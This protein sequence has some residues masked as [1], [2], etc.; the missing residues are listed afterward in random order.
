MKSTWLVVLIGL[1][2]AAGY[3][4]NGLTGKEATPDR[5][6]RE[7][8]AP[9]AAP[10][11]EP[12]TA[13]DSDSPP[14]FADLLSQPDVFS[15]LHMAFE[16]AADSG[17]EKLAALATEALRYEDPLFSFNIAD[18][19]VERMTAIDVDAS[20]DF[21]ESLPAGRSRYQLLTSIYRTWLRQDPEAAHAYADSVGDPRLQARLLAAEAPQGPST[22]LGMR[23]SSVVS[24]GRSGGI[25]YSS[26][27]VANA[28][29]QR[30]LRQSMREMR[31]GMQQDP[32][33]T[34]D[35]LLATTESRERQRVLPEAMALLAMQ[36]PDMA[37]DYLSR[38]PNE[39]RASE[40]MILSVVASQDPQTAAELTEDYARRS[41]DVGP[42][43]A[44]MS[45][46]MKSDPELALASY[47]SVPEQFK[48]QVALAMGSQYMQQDP[49]AGLSWM[50]QQP[51]DQGSMEVL[52]R[53]G[54][55][56]VQSAAESLLYETEDSTAR[57]QLMQAVANSRFR[58]DPAG[59]V[60]WL[61][62]FEQEPG[63]LNAHHNAI[64]HWA[65][66]DPAGAATYLE[67]NPRYSGE[68]AINV[69]SNIAQNWARRDPDAA[70][71]W[72][73][74]LSDPAKQESANRSLVMALV[75][76]DPARA[77]GIYDSLPEGP[78]KYRAG[79]EMALQQSRYNKTQATQIMEGMGIPEEYI[80]RYTRGM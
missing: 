22:S 17:L 20:L 32:E 70:I 12:I 10:L 49:E 54:G 47:D 1:A 42:L 78:N 51:V 21:A 38:F 15:T 7:Y 24:F 43:T 67:D 31:E 56:D 36:D 68:S 75:Q 64:M 30:K 61:E 59:K 63:F 72:A 57:G 73:E 5:A 35:G 60:A 28:A 48:S 46:L 37:L 44:G 14:E 39:L 2:F 55:P 65:G 3:V 13:P 41:G 8:R 52:L 58:E 25:T 76:H 34:I 19:F 77:R 16:I 50:L 74:S 69:I 4:A 53:M 71:A 26:P 27:S 23:N 40:G 62:Q 9:A 33:A 29:E 11:P 80:D 18:I 66:R 45:A 6:P 79:A